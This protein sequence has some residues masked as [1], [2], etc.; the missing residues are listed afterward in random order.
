MAR[1]IIRVKQTIMNKYIKYI[2]LS[3]VAAVVLP[4]SSCYDDGPEYNDGVDYETN[5]AYLYQPDETYAAVEYKANG[6]FLTDFSDP[7]T[8]VP[9]RLTKAAPANITVQVAIDESLV[10]EY[11]T[12]NGTEYTFLT[13]ATIVN[14]TLTIEQGK[15]VSTESISISF[16]DRSGFMKDAT[17]LILPVVITKVSGGNV[18]ISESS[19][20]FLTYNSTYRANKVNVDAASLTVD[21]DEAGWQTAFT[22]YTIEG[23]ATA[24]WAADD[25]ITLGLQIDNSLVADYNS[26]NGTE[27]KA[28][29]ATLSSSQLTIATGDSSADLKLTLGDYTGVADG[30]EYLVPIKVTSFNGVGAALETEVAYL[31][32]SNTPPTYSVGTSASAVGLGSALTPASWTVTS[33]YDSYNTDYELTSE[34]SYLLTSPGSGYFYL[35]EGMALTADLGEAI[36]VSGFRFTFYAWYYSVKS[37]T[38]VEV[39]KDGS[40]WKEWTLDGNFPSNA[41]SIACKFAKSVKCR[42]I[43]FTIGAPSYSSWYGTYATGLYIY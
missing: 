31:Q 24:E 10:E 8:L 5:F 36:N 32:I 6:N 17:D 38:K 18:S 11:N 26:A 39:S 43:R 42:Y 19:R 15:Y 21:T 12:A 33:S 1:S 7:L 37:F 3:A 35:E 2:S 29:D 41:Q 27:Y 30:D 34:C 40:S 9:V 13:G 25:A 14:P 4:L 22:N 16:A 20:V 28:I 23:F